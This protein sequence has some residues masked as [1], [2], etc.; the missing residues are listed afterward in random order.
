[1]PLSRMTLTD[2]FLD[3]TA[4]ITSASSISPP[5]FATSSTDNS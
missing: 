2:F 4:K 5:R 1:M 3:S